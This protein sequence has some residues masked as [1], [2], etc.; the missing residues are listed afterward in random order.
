M[1]PRFLAMISASIFC[2]ATLA[3]AAVRVSPSHRL[4]GLSEPE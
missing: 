4:I 1:I 3:V 2:A